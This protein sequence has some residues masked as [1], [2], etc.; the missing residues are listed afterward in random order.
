MEN[1]IG[2]NMELEIRPI[3]APSVR[4]L[5]EQQ[6]A[7]KII[8]GELKPGDKLPSE[9]EMA[10]KA[11]ISKSAVHLA[12]AD[13]ER[14]GCVATTERQGTYV[15]D[16]RKYGNAMTLGLLTPDDGFVFDNQKTIDILEMRD[17]L[18]VHAL[19]R[20]A[21]N[22]TP[23]D[24][25]I[26]EADCRAVDDYC[27]EA[28]P[29]QVETLAKMFFQFHHDICFCSGNFVLPM[30][31]NSFRYSTSYFWEQPIRELGAER[32]VE[33]LH[34]MMNAILTGDSEKSIAFF[35]QEMDIYIAE[36]SK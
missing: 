23:E 11:Q 9:R 22:M 33:L 28:E 13:L 1:W 15:A 25:E 5:F 29:V 2:E 31:F 36:L 7:E 17:G 35:R 14:L 10:T 16:Y 19:K 4:E 18:E 21:D 6:L 34:G 20:L 12:L 24:I 8:R 3:K 27:K 30:V 32:C 26:L